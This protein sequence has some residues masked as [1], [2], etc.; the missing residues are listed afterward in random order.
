MDK[1][2]Y[3]QKGDKVQFKLSGE[4]TTGTIQKANHKTAWVDS[5]KRHIRKH[6]VVPH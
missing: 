2:T 6:S 5:I 1:A 3:F 4:I